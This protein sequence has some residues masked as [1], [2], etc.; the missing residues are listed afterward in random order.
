MPARIVLPSG[1]VLIERHR[2]MLGFEHLDLQGHR[3]TIFGPSIAQPDQGFPAFEHGARRQCLQSVEVRQAGRIGAFTP[4]PPQGMDG[5]TQGVVLHHRLWL[6]AGADGVRHVGI[7]PGGGPGISAHQI[8]TP[9]A[10]GILGVRQR[11]D[12]TDIRDRPGQGAAA[13]SRRRHR[14]ACHRTDG[15]AGS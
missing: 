4:V 12:R 8:T 7:N 1:Q 5:F 9:G 10:Q 15:Y 3:Q 11:S 2:Q 6:D 13:D 14:G